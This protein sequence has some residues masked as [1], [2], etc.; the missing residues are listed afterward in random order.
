MLARTISRQIETRS[1]SQDMLNEAMV[2]NRGLAVPPG[3]P[4]VDPSTATMHTAVFG[5]VRL[6]STAIAG[7]PL[8]EYQDIT[9]DR[10]QTYKQKSATQPTVLTDPWPDWIQF[11]WMQYMMVS[12]LLRGNAFALIAARDRLGYPTMLMPLPTDQVRLRTKGRGASRR[13]EYIVGSEPV[14]RD[15]VVHMIGFPD[16][17]TNGLTGLSV[18]EH[19]ARTIGLSLAAEEF[20]LRWFTEGSAPAAVLQTDETLEASEVEENQ[21]RWMASHGGMSR[22]PAVLSGGLKYEA[23]SITPEES[24]FLQTQGFGVEQVSRIF[25]LPLHKLGAMNKQSNWGTGVEQQNIGYVTD[26]LQ[27]WMIPWEQ[28]I[29][30]LR[31]RGRYVK[32]NVNAL[33]RGDTAARAKWYTSMRLIGAINND[34]VRAFEDW[35]PIPGGLGEEFSQ[36]FNQG[37]WADARLDD[38]EIP[39]PPPPVED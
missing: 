9:N 30:K 12:L 25:T 38:D 3:T 32:F 36:P 6:L 16:D 2:R 29:T 21:A 31:P 19:F 20:S 24:Q 17:A 1:V 37:D 26:A 4:R 33:L 13:L 22:I 18:I 5:A 34:E 14:D 11:R 10:G 15:D 39:P 28:T 7:L 8:H 27:S 23:V 35:A